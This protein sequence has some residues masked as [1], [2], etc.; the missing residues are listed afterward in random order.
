MNHA[1]LLHVSIPHFSAMLT[2]G[3]LAT[4]IVSA[5]TPVGWST[6]GRIGDTNASRTVNQIGTRFAGDESTYALGLGYAFNRHFALEAT[7]HRFGRYEAVSPAPCPPDFL[8]IA[9][10]GDVALIVEDSAKVTGVSLS[11]RAAWP[12]AEAF[13]LYGKA[14]VLSWRSDFEIFDGADERARDLLLGV[15]VSFQ[16]GRHWRLHVEYE[17]VDVDLESATLGIAFHF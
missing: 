10:A 1:S 2:A 17:D 5:E 3:L 6:H 7:Y 4:S 15:G 9:E 14:G 12:F 13:E 8:C 16:G 11:L